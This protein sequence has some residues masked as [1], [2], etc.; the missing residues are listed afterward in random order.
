MIASSMQHVGVSTQS[1][2]LG[3]CR[4]DAGSILIRQDSY[5][6]RDPCGSCHATRNFPCQ[7]NKFTDYSYYTLR[8]PHSTFDRFAAHRTAVSS[9]H[10]PG[11]E[12]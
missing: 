10:R 1:P 5:A 4:R 12:N 8:P 6:I 11:A 2:R 7:T 3:H 9:L